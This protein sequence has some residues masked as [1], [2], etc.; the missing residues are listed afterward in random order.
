MAGTPMPKSAYFVGKIVQVLAV[1]VLIEVILLLVGGLVYGI[2][3][4]AGAE[5]LLPLPAPVVPGRYQPVPLTGGD[6]AVVDT[7]T[8][9]TWKYAANLGVWGD[10][11]VPAVCYGPQPTLSAG[12][13]DYANEQDVIDCAK[14]YA[15]TAL[16]MLRAV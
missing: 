15:R 4:P 11:G 6:F 16:G 5:W 14:I 12:V 9:H 13:D 7:G 8:G 1:T 3:L 2:R 10:L